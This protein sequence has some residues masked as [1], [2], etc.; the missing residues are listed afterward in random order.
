MLRCLCV[1]ILSIG[2][3][4]STVRAEVVRWVNG[5]RV[6]FG[7]AVPAS[8]GTLAAIDLG[9]APP[10]G[11]SRLF[12]RDELLTVAAQAHEELGAVTIPE[13]VRVRRTTHRFSANELDALV[14]PSLVARLP[15]GAEL[16][17]LVLP[18]SFLSV[19]D[20]QVGQI[21]MP[22]LP[23][24]SG[25]SRLTAVV[26]LVAADALVSRLPVVLAI[27]LD[28]TATRFALPRGAQVELVIESGV[29]RVSATAT[30][31]TPADI[32]DVVVCQVL[33]TR[34]VLRARILTAREATV[35]QQ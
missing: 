27:E 23:K 17:S 33:R 5:S 8:H 34:K 14:R 12:S 4:A 15:R 10:P 13:S 20:L 35:V 18:K 22:R 3:T 2:L 31:L 11:S 21:Q 19:P 7:D 16:R 25:T 32:G 29:A 24:R 1:L 28:E 9:A 26:E 6:S 30:L